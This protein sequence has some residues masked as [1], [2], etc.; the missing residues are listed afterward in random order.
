MHRISIPVCIL[1]LTL[2]ACGKDNPVNPMQKP[3]EISFCGDTSTRYLW[4]FFDIDINRSSGEINAVPMRTAGFNAN[5]V[6]FLQPPA[7]PVNM[8]TISLQPGSDLTSGMLILNVTIRH[9]FLSLPIYRGFDVR[10]IIMSDG[11]STGIYDPTIS[12]HLPDGTRLLNPDGYTRWWNQV[13][14]TSYGIIFGYTEGA[15]ANHAFN[16]TATLNPYK[17]FADGLSPTAPIIALNP[18]SRATFSTSPGINTRQYRI[19]FNI[20]GVPKYRFKY[21]VDASWSLPD[22]QYAPSYPVEAYDLSANC[23]EAYLVQVSDFEEIPYYVNETTYGGDCVFLM[24]IGDWQASSPDDFS[25][26]IA[27]IWVESPTLIPKP[28]DVFPNAKFYNSNHPT[29]ITYRITIPSCTPTGLE[30]QKFLITVESANP[31]TYAPQIQGDPNAF[32]WPKAP[33]AAYAIVDVPISNSGQTDPDKYWIVGLP[34]WCALTEFCTSGADNLQLITNL[35][36]WDL[37]G[38]QNELTKVKWWEGHLTPT[39]PYSTSIIQNHVQSLGYTFERTAEAVFTPD[40]CRMIIVVLVKSPWS[41]SYIPFTQNE[42]DSMRLF[43]KNGG[44]LCFLI[45]NPT[46]FEPEVM[47]DLFDLLG[48]PLGYGGFAEPPSTATITENITPHYLTTNMTTWQYWTCGEWILESPE[49]IS[50]IRTPTNE[51]VVVLAPIEIG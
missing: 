51:D 25:S 44:I 15:L 18:D 45:E 13:E 2:T 30:G 12:Y 47:N 46:Y 4:G 37:E 49:C 23:Q 11:G 50:L 14:F 28:I 48:I 1:L 6:R 3:G 21:A 33:L 5:V 9:P 34:D 36:K 8:L 17:L 38:P 16:S 39:P 43:V 22:P 29:K 35:V 19:Q 31:S 20:S 41:G 7:S 40:G 32:A 10:G 27:H 24:T 42:A 26:Q